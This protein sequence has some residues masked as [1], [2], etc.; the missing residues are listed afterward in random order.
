MGIFNEEI[1]EYMALGIINQ[2]LFSKLP[3]DADLYCSKVSCDVDDMII[4]I[5]NRSNNAHM[6][7]KIIYI[8][9]SAGYYCD[10]VTKII[11]IE[12]IEEEIKIMIKYSDIIRDECIAFYDIFKR[13]RKVIPYEVIQ[14]LSKC[15]NDTLKRI[16]GVVYHDALSKA[17]DSLAFDEFMN[18]LDKYTE[19]CD[20]FRLSV[21]H[22]VRSKSGNTCLV[23]N[24]DNIFYNGCVR[25]IGANG[26]AFDLDIDEE[27]EI[28]EAKVI[29]EN[30]LYCMEFDC[31]TCNEN[32]S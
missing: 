8:R 29:K 19:L 14:H 23:I 22:V 10:R 2:R 20:K 4:T 12:G 16:F 28:S 30:C 15:T 9:D 1:D 32:N 6:E 24:A 11:K 26:Y 7:I 5:S 25:V 27:C 31:G 13:I 18:K 21:G 3:V 17:L